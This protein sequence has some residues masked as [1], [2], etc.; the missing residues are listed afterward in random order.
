MSDQLQLRPPREDDLTIMEKL[1]QDP[2]TGGEFAWFGWHDPLR[3]RRGWTENRLLGDGG[4]AEAHRLL[5][6][7]LFAHTTAHR[8]EAI[9]EATNLAEQRALEKAGFTA[10]GV[11]RAIGWR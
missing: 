11:S 10:E 7:Y 9:T 8:I 4:G 5:A 3:W 6:R 2:D 1:T